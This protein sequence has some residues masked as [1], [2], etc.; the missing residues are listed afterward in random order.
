MLLSRCGLRWLGGIEPAGALDQ[1]PQ[2]GF[3]ITDQIDGGGED[4][5]GIARVDIH[6]DEA[7]PLGIDELRAF[8]MCTPLPATMTGR[9]ARS[10]TCNA[11]STS[12]S[13]AAWGEP[14]R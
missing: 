1:L 12:S 3:G 2:H 14:F 9:S 4:P 13:A 7:L 11:C 6:L 5:A 8:A 10:S